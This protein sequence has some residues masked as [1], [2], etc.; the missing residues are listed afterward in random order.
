[1]THAASNVLEFDAMNGARPKPIISIW[2]YVSISYLIRA[3]YSH[4]GFR[5]SHAVSAHVKEYVKS[6]FNVETKLMHAGA[7]DSFLCKFLRGTHFMTGIDCKYIPLPISAA[8]FKGGMSNN[9]RYRPFS[10]KILFFS[11]ILNHVKI[12]IFR[13]KVMT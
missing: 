6:S 4:F 11:R 1:M 8:L 13:S 5:S 7:Y 12:M 10:S 9:S 3:I 2:S